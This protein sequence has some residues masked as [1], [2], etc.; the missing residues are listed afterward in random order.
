MTTGGVAGTRPRRWRWET[1]MG[2]GAIL[3]EDGFRRLWLGRLLSHTAINA[4]LFT[5]L[6]LAVG[7]GN[8]AS[9]KS[10]LFI[11][12]YLVPTATLGTISGVLVDRLP[13]HLVLT[14][15]NATRAGLMVLLLMSSTALPVVYGVALLIAITSQ[16]A[17][18]AEAASVPQLV[19]QDQLIIANSTSNLGGLVSQIV[20]FTVLPPFFLNTIGARPLFLTTA[21]LFGAASVFFLGIHRLGP[22]AID[23]DRMMDAV[24]NVR[25]Q[26]A[27]GWETLS[28]DT[29][30]YMSVIIFVL[31]STAS[32]VG[33]TL[34]PRFTQET[35]DIPV[36]N[37]V[38]VFLPA[39]VGV[40]AG[41][42]L[43]QWLERHV[44]K[45]WLVGAGFSLLAAS[46]ICLALTRPL[47]NGLE[48][49][50]P[51]GAFDPGP[52]GDTS[53]RIVVTVIFS[54]VATFS[55]SIVGVASRSLV[56]ERVPLEF[57]GRVF[58]AQVVLTNLAS[59]API[60]LAGVLSELAGVEPVIFL[61]VFILIGAAGWTLA[62]AVFRPEMTSHATAS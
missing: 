16:F 39:A 24:R 61:T 28:R 34:M 59:I 31:A 55:F 5:M 17:G 26:F 56:N 22:S 30:A 50:N 37:A 21:V 58:A 11:A 20:G 25:K 1:L 43:V 45:A 27:E 47:G 41:L 32:L 54:T 12:A 7:E 49:L 3:Q 44:R 57:Q 10:A 9:I 35:L 53:A 33:A 4:T 6:V 14:A 8:G 15:V 42:R 52:F 38:F 46:F 29:E 23:V 48:G 60:L 19:R 51:F 36:R 18:P 40:V 2:G 13:K 62:R